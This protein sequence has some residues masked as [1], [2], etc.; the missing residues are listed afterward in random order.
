MKGTLLAFLGSSV[1]AGEG[2]QDVFYLSSARMGIAM[3]GYG[4]NRNMKLPRNMHHDVM[5]CCDVT[6]LSLL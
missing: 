4:R 1:D 2:L 3:A 5:G 6:V